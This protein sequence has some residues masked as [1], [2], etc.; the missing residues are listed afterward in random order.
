MSVVQPE[1]RYAGHSLAERRADRRARLVE[2]GLDIFGSAGWRA[3]PIERI[4]AR[5]SVSTRSFY[6]DVGSREAL[7]LAVY[8]GLLAEATGVVSRA[9]RAAPADLDARVAAGVGAYIEYM[10][11]DPRRARVAHYE[12][13][14]AGILEAERHAGV[15]AFADLIEREAERLGLAGLGG[16]GRLRALALAGALNELLVDWTCAAEPAPTGPLIEEITRLFVRTLSGPLP[17]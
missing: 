2:A 14:T 9:L 10:T 15:T 16:G 5:A 4:C 13:R 11:V 3:A 6:T 1:R 7:L 12:V 8:Q 17:S